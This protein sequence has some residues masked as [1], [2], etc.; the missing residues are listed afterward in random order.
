[1][2]S[3]S[4]TSPAAGDGTLGLRHAE[5]PLARRVTKGPSLYLRTTLPPQAPKAAVALIHGFADHGGRYAHV[6]GAWA[7]RGLATAAID[8]R[9]HGRAE[10]ERGVCERFDEYLDDARELEAAIRERVPGVPYFLF[11]HSFGGLVA[12]LRV[13]DVPA[14]YRGLL[15]TGPNFGIAV[16]VPAMK[17]LAGRVASR[18][19]PS[20]ALPSGLAGADMTHD[21]AAARAYD[22]DPLVFHEARA[23]WF[24]ETVA[25]QERAL[26]RAASLAL[27]LRITMG[28]ADRVSEVDAARRF[29]N[30]ASSADKAFDVRPGLFHEVLNEPEWPAIAGA[31][32]DW[33][34]ARLP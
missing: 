17:K 14:P 31:M 3:V 13:L 33:M 26:L 8:L 2:T 20:F 10:G 9:G 15:L 7:G 4:S 18:I 34:L 28:S 32:A 16:K 24:T 21:A 1:M 5:G 23:R 30:A 22:Q 27:P 29:F 25:A 6:A 12:T 11:G 19:L